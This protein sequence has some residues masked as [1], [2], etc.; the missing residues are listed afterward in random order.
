[1]A[2]LNHH[3]CHSLQGAATLP[4]KVRPS[5]TYTSQALPGQ[6]SQTKILLP[7]KEATFT[8]LA[9]T[10]LTH[11]GAHADTEPQDT[12]PRDGQ[13]PEQQSRID[14]MPREQLSEQQRQAL[15]AGCCG[16]YVSPYTAAADA[17]PIEQT[18]IEASADKTSASGGKTITLEGDVELRQGVRMLRTQRAELNNQTGELLLDGGVTIREDG[19]LILAERAQMQRDSG[20]AKVT[21][22]EFVIHQ[23]RLHGHA[24]TLEKFGDRLLRLADGSF[25]TCEPDHEFWRMEAAEIA[26]HSDQSYGTAK[27]ARLLIK[28]VPVFYMP[29]MAFP[30]GDE[31]KSGLLFPSIGS[32]S[33]NGLEVAQPIYWNIAPQMDATITPRIM[34]K[35]GTLWDA[36]V[37]HLTSYFDTQ[38]SGGFLASD[39][40]GYDK[41]AE[42]AIALGEK[43]VAEAY[44]HLG[45]DRWLINLEQTGGKRSRLKTQIDYTDISDVDYV[46]DVTSSDIDVSRQSR[47][48][49]FGEISYSGD[50]WVVG[51]SAQEVRYLN[52]STQEP[53]KQVPQLFAQSNLRFG[54]WQID[55]DNQ[56]TRFDISEYYNLATDQLVVGDRLNTDYGITWDKRWQWGFV[57]PRV[58]VKSLS[59]QLQQ[60]DYDPDGSIPDA[61][62]FDDSP[63]LLVP[64]A[65]VDMGLFFERFGNL[66]GADFIQTLEP[67]L[68]YFYS[69]YEDHSALYS[70]LNSSNKYLEFDTKYVNF[71][72]NQLFRTTRF[73]GY[74]RID[75]AN[76][77]SVGFTSRFISPATG[78]E[79]LEISVGQIYRFTPP[80]V[81]LDPALQPSTEVYRQS[82][83]AGRIAARA[84]NYLQVS[85]DV[86]YDQHQNEVSN[87]GTTI[88]YADDANRLISLTYT[89]KSRASA[90]TTVDPTELSRNQLDVGAFVPVSNSWSIIARSNYDL[91]YQQELDTFAGFE[92]S[93]CCYRV[94]LLWRKWLNS[95]YNDGTILG[96]VEDIDYD[97][98]FFVDIQLKGLAS[99]SERVGNLL[100]KTI[101]GYQER[102]QNLR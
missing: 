71:D 90:Q 50:T 32:G 21:N 1:M 68:F 48:S 25:T 67:R 41:Q 61:A 11:S 7:I 22:A 45:K 60:A 14:W 39:D 6:K 100:D 53:Y 85:G 27:H 28:G 19:L 91:A 83:F 97:K 86:L 9:L 84:G 40:G 95:D 44:P 72:Y 75:D 59:Y 70:P 58:G 12:Y 73:S 51:A 52:E 101:L 10:V 38:V 82:E 92:Y 88:E 57:K 5:K 36:D 99:I 94:R 63:S 37:R 74:D 78:V 17:P 20:D 56:F 76:Q 55:L 102:E 98:G 29:Y 96:D 81:T 65:S 24:G 26:I 33:R 62:I 66:G 4:H 89:Y 79:H 42:R 77:L 69:D 87:A 18:D 47:I 16:A 43:T 15:P 49:K 35:R 23:T 13:Q 31:R 46:R 8:L 93:D 64:Q 80:R 54:D 34:E 30:V 3:I 2:V